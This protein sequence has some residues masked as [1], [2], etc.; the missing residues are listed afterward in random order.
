MSHQPSHYE[1]LGVSRVATDKEIRSAYRRLV[2]QVHPDRSNDPAA[3]EKFIAV[4]N[5]YEALIDPT[6]R[7]HYDVLLAT[8]GAAPRPAPS[9]P[10][11]RPKTK[12]RAEPP[13]DRVDQ[14]KAEADMRLRHA[15]E[16]MKLTSLFARGKTA[17]AERLAQR[18]IEEDPRGALPYA[19]LADIARFRGD[20]P[21][22]A[23]L[24]GYAAQFAPGNPTYQQKHEEILRSMRPDSTAMGAAYVWTPNRSR[25]G[26][27]NL[28]MP[29]GAVVAICGLYVLLSQE[30]PMFPG[31][32]LL[33]TWTLGLVGMLAI[34]GVAVGACLSLG[35][36]LDAFGPSHSAGTTR[37]SPNLMLAAAAAIQFWLA[38]LMY[39]GIAVSQ[40]AVNASTSR[41][42]GSVAAVVGVAALLCGLATPISA[43]QVLLWGGNLT[44][45]AAVFGWMMADA[46]RSSR[47]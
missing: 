12:P 19:V 23:E 4:R 44:Y 46:F 21:R 31:I 28:L 17:D 11:V 9:P 36:Y 24:Y 7:A 20:M 30:R 32:A 33:D 34:S 25:T 47:Y 16:H 6:R 40:D 35:G 3:T 5:A 29:A 39:F 43:W 13:K 18:L 10:P 26:N 45:M 38:A 2:V 1:I 14:R 22:A 8:R 37:V 27:P 15:Q 41:I 42:M